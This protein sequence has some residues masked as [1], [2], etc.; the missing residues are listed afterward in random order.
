MG[1]GV[2][3]SLSG[4][5]NVERKPVEC[6]TCYDS[7]EC[8]GRGHVPYPCPKCRQ[9]DHAQY[10]REKSIENANIPRRFINATVNGYKPHTPSQKTA[11]A[12]VSDYVVNLK[13]NLE[14]GQGLTL[15]GSVGT[16][17]THLAVAILLAA[18]ERG[19]SV[20]FDSEDGIF[21]H[22]KAEWGEPE[23]EMQFLTKLQKVRF[24]VIDD[25]GIRRPSDY[26]SDRYEA[27]INTRYANGLPTIITTNRTPE[28]LSEVYER[29]MS[30][31]SENIT[32]EVLG[33]D[34]RGAK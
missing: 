2:R 33:P 8:Y 16:G 34:M 10:Q 14:S 17:K 7:G 31:L 11:K 6:T 12:I 5:E 1:Y 20:H 32:M 30:R 13:N 28:Q 25:L 23:K 3:E 19:L 26:V 29:Q 4:M 15:W 18:Q 24:L 9:V 21:D 22:F 27:I